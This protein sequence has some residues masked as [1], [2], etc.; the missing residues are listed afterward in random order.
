M[1]FIGLLVEK[2]GEQV[3]RDFLTKH[4]KASND[5]IIHINEKTIENVKHISFE[6]IVVGKEISLDKMEIFKTML[7]KATYIV[8]HADLKNVFSSLEK[9]NGVLITYGFNSKATITASSVTEDEIMI[10][11][12]RNL[13]NNYGEKIEA[14]EFSIHVDQTK[15]DPN[16]IMAAYAI[17]LI[18][19]KDK[20]I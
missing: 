3:I 5:K 19:Q 18:Y 11:L 7:Q 12:Q 10:C 1:P 15:E 9:I 2:K 4:L 17:T 6:T 20:I 14:Q 8:V 13:I 16:D